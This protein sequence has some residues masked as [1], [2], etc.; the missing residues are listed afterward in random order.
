[1]E[2]AN[3]VPLALAKEIAAGPGSVP[4][5]LLLFIRGDVEALCALPFDINEVHRIAAR[6]PSLFATYWD[7]RRTLERRLPPLDEQHPQ[8]RSVGLERHPEDDAVDRDRRAR[9]VAE[10]HSV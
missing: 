8:G 7:E 5:Q 2:R 1:M 6:E 3:V 10:L 4:C 9:V